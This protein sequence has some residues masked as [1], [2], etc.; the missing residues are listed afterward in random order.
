VSGHRIDVHTHAMRAE[1][2][3]A[4]AARGYRPTG[5]YRIS[6][7]WTPEAALSYMAP[8]CPG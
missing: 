4:L 1:A 2:M 7:Q 3:A 8:D 5:G 6:V